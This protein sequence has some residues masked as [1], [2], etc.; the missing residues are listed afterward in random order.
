MMKEAEGDFGAY[1]HGQLIDATLYNIRRERRN[2]LCA[3]AL[4]WEDLKRWR[5][6]DQLKDTPFRPQGMLYWGS[7]YE[8][9]TKDKCI[10]DPAKGNMSPESSGPYIYPYEKITV[11]NDI[12]NQG[13]FKFTPAH[14]LEPIGAAVFRQTAS[15]AGDFTSSNVYQNPGWLY[16][17]NTGA[18]SVE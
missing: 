7:V 16:E 8:E 3:E 14:Y 1:S 2:E 10:V 4:R 15:D 11:N 18:V 5:A 9:Q 6:L 12:Y 17:A 13:G